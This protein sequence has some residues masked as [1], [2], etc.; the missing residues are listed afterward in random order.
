MLTA[1]ADPAF[2]AELTR[3]RAAPRAPLTAAERA[4]RAWWN[5]PVEPAS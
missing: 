4:D 2:C 5:L 1:P 3:R